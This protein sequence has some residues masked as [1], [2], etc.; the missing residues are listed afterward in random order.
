[1]IFGS[2]P[3]A[4][5]PREAGL[6][7]VQLCSDRRFHMMVMEKF[8]DV[9]GLD[10]DGY[11]IEARPGGAPSWA[12]NTRASRLAYGEGAAHMAWAAHGDRCG[13]FPGVSNSDLRDKLTRTVRK[14]AAEFP[15]ASHYG[16]FAHG[17]D[18]ELVLRINPARG[19]VPTEDPR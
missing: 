4:E 18:V 2:E 7:F 19:G 17:D 9:A 16:L 3:R 8:E 13:G 12:D 10:P 14:R 15:R 1:M 11:W 5:R 6:G